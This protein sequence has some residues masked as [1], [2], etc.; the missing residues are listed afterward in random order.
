MSTTQQTN[1]TVGWT[2]P[3]TLSALPEAG[4]TENDEEQDAEN[5]FEVIDFPDP[6][7]HGMGTNTV[8]NGLD[9]A[10]HAEDDLDSIYRSFLDAWHDHVE[11]PTNEPYIIIEDAHTK[12]DWANDDYHAH[13]VLKSSR[14]MVGT[15]ANG[16]QITDGQR[17]EYSLQ[18]MRY[19]PETGDLKP[20]KPLPVNFQVWIRPQERG[21]VYKSRDELELPFGTGTKF[22]TQTTYAEPLEAI[23][24]TLIVVTVALE[25]LDQDRPDWSDMNRESMKMWKGEVHHRIDKELMGAACETL[26]EAK[27]LI[28]HGGGANMDQDSKRRQA[29]RV[30]E[31][32]RCDRW[33][34]LGFAQP[35]G[36]DIGC[37]VY[38]SSNWMN[39][40]D[41][42]YKNPKIE[43]FIA[44]THNDQELPHIRE[45]TAMR[46]HL[47]QIATGLA[48]RSG[49]R[50]CD[51]V[52]DDYYR[53]WEHEMI[54]VPI[55]QGWRAKIEKAI[56]QR[57]RDIYR[58]TMS[59]LTR[60]RWDILWVTAQLQGAT[61]EQLQ[62]ITGLSY[63]YVRE[64]VRELKD[65]EVLVRLTWPRVIAFDTEELRINALDLLQEVH[66]DE[67]MHEIRE[68]AEERRE[69][70]RQQRENNDTEE[71]DE[72]DKSD[73]SSE[74][75]DDETTE[76][77]DDEHDDSD[78]MPA[79]EWRTFD[80][81]DLLSPEELRNAL[82][83][84]FI[85][86]IHVAVRTD[87]Y[88][89]ID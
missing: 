83:R 31:L 12:F 37:K 85:D 15:E 70:R 44:G 39:Y 55:P 7:T 10:A 40:S 87:P 14:W 58:I 89:W 28:N 45:W 81:L 8:V 86:E 79:G 4:D 13:L 18:L 82:E 46:A 72:T 34:R 19:D 71:S 75:G 51:L 17:Y 64:L 1:Q 27:R 6:S 59:S 20:K 56:E 65:A 2:G 60:A 32:V 48:V 61:Y 53:A 36:I 21:L 5:Q 16:E 73:D 63:D 77:E 69:K 35:E 25:I 66:P 49:V 30:R 54:D 41:S 88:D 29:G 43:A 47:R 33:D 78:Q 42:T 11:D 3:K 23:N 52:Q 24:R 74:G 50:V 9:D 67:G 22:H 84:D 38:R 26:A 62:E 76:T 68:R 57:Q 80:A